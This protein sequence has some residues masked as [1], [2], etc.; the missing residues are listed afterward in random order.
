MLGIEKS[1]I[2]IGDKH[3]D[4]Y[5]INRLVSA[6]KTAGCTLNSSVQPVLCSVGMI[7]FSL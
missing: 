1:A 3:D 5:R 7:L 4:L 2:R 6:E